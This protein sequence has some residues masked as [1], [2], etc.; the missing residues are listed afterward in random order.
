M[1][2]SA[3]KQMEILRKTELRE[4][5]FFALQQAADNGYPPQEDM[6]EA[7]ELIDEVPTISNYFGVNGVM[8][9]E[10]EPKHIAEV[11]QLIREWREL[12]C[13]EQRPCEK[14]STCQNG[15]PLR[16]SR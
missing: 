14:C 1:T 12:A 8:P 11:V 10:Y 9:G 6:L 5:V 16:S 15:W 7:M 2:A 3:E 13:T 4:A